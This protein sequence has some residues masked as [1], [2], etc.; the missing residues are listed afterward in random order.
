MVSSQLFAPG[1]TCSRNSNALGYKI[2]FALERFTQAFVTRAKRQT[3]GLVGGRHDRLGQSI[4]RA[5]QVFLLHQLDIQ[6]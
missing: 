5:V 2:H 3:E 4:F 6:A 1:S